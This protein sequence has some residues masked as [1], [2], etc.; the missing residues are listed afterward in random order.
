[1]VSVNAGELLSM[2]GSQDPAA[3][4]AFASIGKIEEESNK[5]YNEIVFRMLNEK[6]IPNAR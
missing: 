3:H 5:K 1:M 4:V 6:N 2:G